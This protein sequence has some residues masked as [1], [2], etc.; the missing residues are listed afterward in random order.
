MKNRRFCA[1]LSVCLFLVL[2]GASRLLA[3]DI[4]VAPAKVQAAV[5]VKALAFNKGLAAGGDISIHVVDSPEFATA[6][7]KGIGTA[8][9]KAR[10]GAVT[11]GNGLPAEKPAVVYLGD[12]SRRDEI[13]QYTRA[14]KIMS[15]T[16]LPD[17][18]QKGITMGV[19]ILRDKPKIILNLSS[20]R[21]EGI[22]WNPALLK[23]AAVTK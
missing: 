21:E 6:M 5:F 14:N 19:G 4:G 12:A 11:E 9:G 8:V 2:A 17:Q 22:D 16:G 23:I 3:E 7:K 20:S 18:V 1:I 13:I 10:I 15:I